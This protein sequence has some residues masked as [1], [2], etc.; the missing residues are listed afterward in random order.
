VVSNIIAMIDANVSAS[1]MTVKI[2]YFDINKS[3]R[4]ISFMQLFV[5]DNIGAPYCLLADAG[6]S[7][8]IPHD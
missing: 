3:V 7:E 4:P 5:S 1:V 8:P 6:S 2:G